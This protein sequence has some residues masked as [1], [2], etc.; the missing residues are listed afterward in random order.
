MVSLMSVYFLRVNPV[1]V[2]GPAFNRARADVYL[3][4][5]TCASVARVTTMVDN[6]VAGFRGKN[7][8]LKPRSHAPIFDRLPIARRQVEPVTGKKQ[9]ELF[10]LRSLSR[11]VFFLIV[12]PC[13][14]KA[15]IS[16]RT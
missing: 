13:D 14:F 15:S 7:A 6:Q 4:D 8:L 11:F 9:V 2:T 3:C 12:T 10:H 1:E 16:S 5:S